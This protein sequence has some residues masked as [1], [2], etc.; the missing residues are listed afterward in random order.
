M[1][2]PLGIEMEERIRVN[3]R[4]TA[5]AQSAILGDDEEAGREG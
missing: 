4:A 5:A 3:A 1:S 2:R